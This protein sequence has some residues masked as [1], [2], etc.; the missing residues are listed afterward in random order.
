M[1]VSKVLIILCSFFLAYTVK[2]LLFPND[3]ERYKQAVGLLSISTILAL[4]A[5]FVQ[6]AV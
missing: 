5:Y 4:V 6:V 1:T 3:S 2:I